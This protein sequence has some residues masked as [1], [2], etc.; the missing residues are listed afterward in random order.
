VSLSRALDERLLRLLRCPVCEGP[1]HAGDGAVRCPQRH[2]FNVARQGYV[3]L[4]T[5][6]PPTS[7]D[8]SGMVAARSRFLA[9]GCYDAVRRAVANTAVQAAPD[10]GVVVDAGCG[11]GYYLAGVLGRLPGFWG[12]GLDTSAAS[13]RAAARAHERAGAAT[14]DVFRPL[15]LAS[16]VADLVLDVFAPRNPA[17]FHRILRPTGR[18]VVARPTG[19]HLVELSEQVPA[20]VSVDPKKE[21]RLHEALDP[22]FEAGATER[23]EYAAELTGEQ[24]QDLLAMTPTARHRDPA[25]DSGPGPVSVTVSVLVT[26]YQPR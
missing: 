6:R 15:P 5:G 22:Y 2:T 17:E 10:R 1:L 23:V 13:L 12:L 26:A 9:T 7:G 11:T 4:L 24:S 3:S 14:W 25:T 20:M 21:Q 16:G 19:R 8:D 18:L